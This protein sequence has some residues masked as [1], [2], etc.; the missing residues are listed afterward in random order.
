MGHVEH[1]AICAAPVD[2]VFAYTSDYR[3]VPQWMMGIDELDPVGDQTRG[4]GAV[5]DT[6]V[7]LGPKALQ[8]RMEVVDWVE[9]ETLAFTITKALDADLLWR[10]ESTGDGETRI[11]AVA[12]YTIPG[13]LAGRMLDPLIQAFARVAVKHAERHLSAQIEERYAE[14]RALAEG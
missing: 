14:S 13:R 4:V 1:S 6:A 7:D 8:L 2:F 11:S 12:S 9:G 10:F 5:F 3:N